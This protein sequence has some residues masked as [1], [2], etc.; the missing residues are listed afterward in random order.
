MD[1]PRFTFLRHRSGRFDGLHAADYAGNP[2]LRSSTPGATS[3]R[4]TVSIATAEIAVTKSLRRRLLKS[5]RE[6]DD[7]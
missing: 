5:C 3:T 1:A 7:D 4:A 2:V 6:R